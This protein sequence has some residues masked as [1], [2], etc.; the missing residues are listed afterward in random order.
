MANIESSETSCEFAFLAAELV[1]LAVTVVGDTC[2]CWSEWPWRRS[3]VGNRLLNLSGLEGL[4]RDTTSLDIS[5][6]PR[7]PSGVAKI[8]FRVTDN[9]GGYDFV[10]SKEEVLGHSTEF[11]QI[12][13]LD[14]GSSTSRSRTGFW[15]VLRWVT[16]TTAVARGRDF[17]MN[18]LSRLYL[19]RQIAIFK[20]VLHAYDVK[21]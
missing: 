20:Q 11:C 17:L 15:Y 6:V 21:G 16:V 19:S 18:G 10:Q 13:L 9:I 12:R 1:V 5:A 2:W 3:G 14:F 4:S 7:R 8:I